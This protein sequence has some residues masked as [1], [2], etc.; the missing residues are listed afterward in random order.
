MNTASLV[1]IRSWKSV[2]P[3]ISAHC[4]KASPIRVQSSALC[5]MFQKNVSSVLILCKGVKILIRLLRFTSTFSAT[6]SPGIWGASTGAVRPS[7]G[8]PLV[9]GFL[10]GGAARETGA[11]HDV[12]IQH[13]QQ[14][15]I[16]RHHVLHFHAVEVVHAFVAAHMKRKKTA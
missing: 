7:M 14:Q 6:G 5:R 11:V 4:V 8:L 10:L 15:V 2:F 16:Q 1:R 13:L 12:G 9:P 3:R